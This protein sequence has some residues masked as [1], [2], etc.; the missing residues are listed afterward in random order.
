MPR[1]AQRVADYAVPRDGRGQLAR[2]RVALVAAAV[3]ALDEELV[4]VS[5]PYAIEEARPVAIGVFDQ[6]ARLIWVPQLHATK[7]PAHEDSL[8]AR[9]PNAE[10]GAC[11]DQCGAHRRD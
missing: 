7:D 4:Q 2:I 9:R 5:V 6:Q 8:R 3:V 1:E 11:A 10:G